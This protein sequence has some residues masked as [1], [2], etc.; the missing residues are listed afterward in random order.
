MANTAIAIAGDDVVLSR[1]EATTRDF[2]D[3]WEREDE[4]AIV[5]AF[6]SDAVYHN[7][8]YKPIQGE[9]KIRKAI[10]RFLKGGDD[11]TFDLRKLIIAGDTVVTERM[12]GWSHKGEHKEM[13]VMGILEFNDDGKITSWREYFDV[14][15]FEGA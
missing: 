3:A 9:E 2:F 6:A 8:P 11:M 15:T 10:Q 1:N 4:E 12:D 7:I 13:P 14:K 5:G